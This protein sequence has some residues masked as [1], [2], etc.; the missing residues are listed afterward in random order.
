MAGRKGMRRLRTRDRAEQNPRG[1]MVRLS[2]PAACQGQ[3]DVYRG[4]NGAPTDAHL[5]Q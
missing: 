1:A 5:R 2:R 4:V 3:R